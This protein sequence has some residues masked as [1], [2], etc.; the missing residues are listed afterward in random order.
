VIT[1]DRLVT[2]QGDRER[3]VQLAAVEDVISR[4]FDW[5]PIR[6]ARIESWQ[7]VGSAQRLAARGLPVEVFAPTAKAHSEEWPLLAQALA[8]RTIV[9]PRHE[10]LREELLGLAY[11][12]TPTGIRVSDRGAVHQ[13]HATVVRMLCAMLTAPAPRPRL[14][15]GDG[16]GANWIVPPEPAPF[17][18][19]DG[20]L[21]TT[22]EEL[23]QLAQGINPWAR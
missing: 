19:D 14:Y 12:V 11:E 18:V 15:F 9:L 13:D 5:F 2:L 21:E 10:R 20:T 3:P 23:A 22:P 16:T 8:N 17:P 6:R 4:L 7:G 1:I